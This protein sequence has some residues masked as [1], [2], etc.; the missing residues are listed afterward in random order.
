MGRLFD[1]AAAL[2]GVC[3]GQSYEGQAAMELEALVST[4]R[5]LPGGYRISEHV[6][7]FRPLLSALLSPGL[8]KRDGAELF[9]GTLIAGLAEWI[10]RGATQTGQIQVVLGGGCI[11]NRVLAEG[12]AGALRNRGLV[13]WLPHSV[14]ANDGGLSLGQAAMARS[15]LMTGNLL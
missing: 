14:P 3:T 4:P 13:P 5:E 10:G 6:L 2:L 11:M 1:A 9:H 8:T 15:H 7:D 12:L